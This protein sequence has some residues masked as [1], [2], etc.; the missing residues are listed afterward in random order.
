[1]ELS[2]EQKLQ[3]LQFLAEYPDNAN[4]R[5]RKPGDWYCSVSGVE[6]KQ[7][8]CLVGQYGNGTTPQ[9]AVE[10]CFL[11]L[12]SITNDEVLVRNAMNA[13]KRTYFRWIGFM[14]K[15]EASEPEGE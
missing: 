11:V 12:T 3:A 14:W 5:M 9:E 2:W 1:M 6:V 8:H 13:E 7:K 4:V 10:N 15:Q